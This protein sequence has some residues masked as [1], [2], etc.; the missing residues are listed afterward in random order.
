MRFSQAF[1]LFNVNY[2]LS[3]FLFRHP[4][5]FGYKVPV[6][7]RLLL[8]FVILNNTC[9]RYTM[10]AELSLRGGGEEGSGSYILKPLPTG[11]VVI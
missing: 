5:A 8:V 10:S 11:L 6:N 9:K 2:V 4:E 3:L 7:E 1:C